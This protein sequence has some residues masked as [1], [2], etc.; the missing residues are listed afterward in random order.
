MLGIILAVA[1]TILF[2]FIIRKISFFHIEGISK[3]VFTA[4]FLLKIIFGFAFWAVYVW[5]HSYSERADAFLYF[6]DGKAIYSALFQHPLDYFKILLGVDDP[7]LSKYLGQTGHWNMTYVQGLYNETRTVIRFN[8]IVDVFSF[9]NYHVH[10]VFMCF[11]SFAGL[12]GIYKTFLPFLMEKKKELFACVFLLPSVLFWSS[13][14]LKEGLILF[15]MGML[16]YHVFRFLREGFTIRRFIW[17]LIFGVLLS[18]TKLY[19]LLIL[20]PAFIAHAWIVKTSGKFS[21]IK[22]I[23]VF[24]VMLAALMLQSKINIPFKLMDKQRQNIYLASGG[25]LI[26]KTEEHKFIYIKPKIQNRIVKLENKPGYCKIAEGVPYVSWYFD[27]FTDSSYVLHSADTST[28]WV[29][30]DLPEA[31]SYIEIPFLFPSWSSV[32]KNSPAAFFT[33][34]FRPHLLE[35]KKNPLIILSAIEN[36][37]IAVFILIC[38]FF[39]SKKIE[40]THVIYFCISTVILL[41]VLTGLTTPILGSVVRYK[42]PVLPFFLIA[43]LLILDKEKLLNKLP[44]LRR[45]LR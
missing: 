24:A 27:D 1:Y 41:F 36:F 20:I 43:F 13:G 28:Y 19:M 45:I 10:T 11:L 18:I 4:A 37:F 14:V 42:I 32:L 15:S 26:G 21:I 16:V 2:I 44:F 7:S 9:G 31:G 22:Y 30:Y 40:H 39:F 29:Y 35:T 3:N 23:A 25:S 33:S 5:R 38:I 6:D 17:I 12:T 8:A 34:A